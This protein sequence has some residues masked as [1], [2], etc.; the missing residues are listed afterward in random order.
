MQK[1]LIHCHRSG[2]VQEASIQLH[3]NTISFL[4]SGQGPTTLAGLTDMLERWE[5]LDA[6][7]E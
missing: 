3:K 4:W 5:K 7:M 1:S 6:H 2:G